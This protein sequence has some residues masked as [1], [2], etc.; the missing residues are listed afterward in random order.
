[1]TSDSKT[2]TALFPIFMAFD[3]DGDLVTYGATGVGGNDG[4]NAVL[5]Y[6]SGSTGAAQPLAGWAFA[7]AEFW[8]P[9]PTG[10]ALDASG[11]FYTNAALHTALGPQY[12]LY[13]ALHSDWD[14]PS[15]T[16]SRTIPWNSTSELDPDYTNDVALDD[17]GEIYIAN[18]VLVGSGSYPSCQGRTN[19]YSSGPS[20]SGI[21][22]LRILTFDGVY[23]SNP[24]CLS[25]S[26]PLVPFFPEITIYGST[27]F[28]ADDFNNA[29]D[30]FASGGN[31]TVKPSSQIT[32]SSTDLNAPIA[33]AITS[34]SGQAK[35]RP[36]RPFVALH[37]QN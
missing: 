26:N 7:S 20:S 9:G 3:S 29:I 25:S 1:L 34:A 8:Y 22:P 32:G 2:Q 6:A 35:A 18:T 28:V 31:G 27:L 17:S 14:N 13:V 4:N 30:T 12:G 15:S 11:N 16:A 19:V 5:T 24:D 10:L 21:T 23:T 37:T 36:A 33:L